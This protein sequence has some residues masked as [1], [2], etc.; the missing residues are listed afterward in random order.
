MVR[1]FSNSINHFTYKN[2]CLGF[3]AKR[4]SIW[5]SGFNYSV[6]SRVTFGSSRQVSLGIRILLALITHF[7]NNVV[8]YLS[9]YFS[10][11]LFFS[12]QN[13]YSCLI[14]FICSTT[15]PTWPSYFSFSFCNTL[16][17]ARY[18]RCTMQDGY[19]LQQSLCILLIRSLTHFY[20]ANRPCMSLLIWHLF[21]SSGN[22]Q[23][24]IGA[25]VTHIIMLCQISSLITYY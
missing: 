2:Y 4:Y 25:L 8:C 5:K 16:Y 1:L 19:N 17:R 6:D 23:R 21:L 14:Q 9:Y 7:H 24:N 11:L 10:I 12:L 18:K 15:N 3:I 13:T 22:P 20:V